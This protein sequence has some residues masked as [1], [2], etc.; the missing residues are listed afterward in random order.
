MIAT[1]VVFAASTDEFVYAISIV[2]GRQTWRT[3]VGQYPSLAPVYN[4]MLLVSTTAGV[5]ALDATSGAERWH[6]NLYSAQTPV[7]AGG[8]V[9]VGGVDNGTSVIIALDAIDGTQHWSFALGNSI[10]GFPTTPVV[11][12]DTLFVSDTNGFVYAIGAANGLQLW[13]TQVIHVV[14]GLSPLAVADGIIYVGGGNSASDYHLFALTASDGHQLWSIKTDGMVST[15]TLN[16][17]TLYLVE[18]LFGSSD[19]VDSYCYALRASDGTQIWRA[20]LG[21]AVQHLYSTL[22]LTPSVLKQDT[23]Y[24]GSDDLAVH[25]LSAID[26]SARWR[27]DMN[28]YMSYLLVTA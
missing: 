3:H 18:Q 26:G 16:G 23:L 14:P 19:G 20:P 12:G 6:H 10:E 24:V 22:Q 1:D 5:S 27:T 21:Q 25:A 13:K 9:Y 8:L 28:G 7:V 11:V 15:P 17:G 4:G 2:D